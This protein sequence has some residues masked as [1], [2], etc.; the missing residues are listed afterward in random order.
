MARRQPAKLIALLDEDC[1]GAHDESIHALGG[2]TRKCRVN[3]HPRCPAG[4]GVARSG[5][6]STSGTFE[7]LLHPQWSDSGLKFAERVYRR[8]VPK[9]T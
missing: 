2:E 8:Y 4:D 6:P 5:H 3:F 9:P 1:I 7:A